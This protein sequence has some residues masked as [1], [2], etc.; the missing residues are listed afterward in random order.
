MRRHFFEAGALGDYHANLLMVRVKP[1]NNALRRAARDVM[2]AYRGNNLTETTYGLLDLSVTS[3]V[4]NLFRTEGF[5]ALEYY[6][7][8]GEI[9]S[10]TPLARKS[11]TRG[12]GS[13][14]QSRA[15]MTAASLFEGI[16]MRRGT[17]IGQRIEEGVSIIEMAPD[18]DVE[19]L[20]HAMAADPNI[21]SVTKIPI[22]YLCARPARPAARPPLGGAAA[23]WNLRKIGWD[24]VRRR[25]GFVEAQGIKVAVLDTGIDEKHPDLKR[26]VRHYEWFG[27]LP[28]TVTSAEDIVGHGT[29]VAGTIAADIS[30]RIGIAGVCETDLYVWKIFNDEPVFLG[31]AFGYVVDPVMYLRALFDCIDMEVDVVNLSIGGPG[32]PSPQEAQAFNALSVADVAVVAAMGNERRQGSP[33]SYPAAITDVIAVGATRPDDR[34]AN[35]SNRG[36]HIAVSAP[37]AAIWST[38]PDYPGQFGFEVQ[39]DASGR[40]Q[41][42]KP[43]YRERD[44]DAWDGTSMATPHVAA[45]MALYVA[46][47]KES[48]SATYRPPLT[49]MR[50]ALVRSCDRV[51]EMGGNS[52]HPDYGAGRIN[53]VKLLR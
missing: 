48:S 35:F 25:P 11:P 45:A 38:L 37:G 29:H 47:T 7:R 42:G 27:D 19:S 9:R 36:N 39:Y 24:E 52:F 16:G 20:S 28:N 50:K 3:D 32:E 46:K 22:R 44:Y 1:D 13:A 2:S 15:L 26:H 8:A 14:I 10:V 12:V 41:Q 21:D 34:V 53:L 17:R 30:N 23:M 43:L 6:R 4:S 49:A 18:S 51:P 40:P 31:D 33:T 5:E